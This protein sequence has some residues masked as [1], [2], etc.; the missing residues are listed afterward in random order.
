VKN[1]GFSFL[2]GGNEALYSVN[3]SHMGILDF[4]SQPTKEKC[5]L[6]FLI[7]YQRKLSVKMELPSPSSN[8]DASR[9]VE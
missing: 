7:W 5:T 4:H 2:P 9:A 1:Q 3:G 6:P 8:N